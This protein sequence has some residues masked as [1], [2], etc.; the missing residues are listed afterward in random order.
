MHLLQLR[1]QQVGRFKGLRPLPDALLQIGERSVFLLVHG[2]SFRLSFSCRAVRFI[3]RSSLVFEPGEIG[4]AEAEAVADLPGEPGR[5]EPAPLAAECFHLPSVVRHAVFSVGVDNTVY[6]VVVFV[7]QMAAVDAGEL[8]AQ[9]LHERCQIAVII[10]LVQA[11]VFFSPD[12]ELAGCHAIL[13]S[14]A[15]VNGRKSAVLSR[16]CEAMAAHLT[17]RRVT[18]TAREARRWLPAGLF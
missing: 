13:L 15:E 5:I 10:G 4:V 17:M 6:L 7:V 9:H 16:R 2:S 3:G 14:L 18:G 1:R 11:R 12:V 8:L